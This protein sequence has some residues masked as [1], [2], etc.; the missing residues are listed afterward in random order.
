MTECESCEDD[1]KRRITCFHC[2]EKVCPHCWHHI[3][4]CEPGH[5]RSECRD[6]R[7][8]LKYGQ[9]WIRRLRARLKESEKR[10]LLKQSFELGPCRICEP[11]LDSASP[12]SDMRCERCKLSFRSRV[13]E[14]KK[15]KVVERLKD[16]RIASLQSL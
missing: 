12:D 6:Y 3:H 13:E 4:S 10:D 9:E 11:K 1:C 14:L 8:Y 7:R 2:G 16:G 15:R 5:K